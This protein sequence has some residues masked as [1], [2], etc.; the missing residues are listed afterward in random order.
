MITVFRKKR[1]SMVVKFCVAA[2]PADKTIFSFIKN[3]TDYDRVC[4]SMRTKLRDT[5][6]IELELAGVDVDGL[7]ASVKRI[8]DERGFRGWQHKDGESKIYGGFSLTYNPDHQDKLDPH[9][10]L[11]FHGKEFG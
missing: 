1:L 8:I 7:L 9:T 10:S 5:E 4:R 3:S 2:M 6:R 11:D